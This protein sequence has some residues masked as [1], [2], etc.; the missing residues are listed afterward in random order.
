MSRKGKIKTSRFDR[1]DDIF[2]IY[3]IPF[4]VLKLFSGYNEIQMLF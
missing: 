1:N 3:F 2:R 4:E